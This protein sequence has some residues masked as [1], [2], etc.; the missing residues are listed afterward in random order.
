[1]NNSVKF[2]PIMKNN[3]IDLSNNLCK[4]NKIFC[5]G[6]LMKQRTAECRCQYFLSYRGSCGPWFYGNKT[7]IVIGYYCFK[8]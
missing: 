4:I 3:R 5:N 7:V 2:Q 1:M 8:F 6:S